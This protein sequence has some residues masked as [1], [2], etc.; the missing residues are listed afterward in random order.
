M[1]EDLGDKLQGGQGLVNKGSKLSKTKYKDGARAPLG[2]GEL[3][4]WI[5]Y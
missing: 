1:C 5:S 4:I 2:E 3:M